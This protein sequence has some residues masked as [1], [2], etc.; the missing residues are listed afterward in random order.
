M[1]GTDSQKKNYWCIFG[2]QR[3]GVTSFRCCWSVANQVLVVLV[4]SRAG[5]GCFPGVGFRHL[6]TLR[7]SGFLLYLG[8]G[9]WATLRTLLDGF[10]VEGARPEHVR[11]HIFVN[12]C[13]FHR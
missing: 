1:F 9:F 11:G 8:K 5:W 6:G 3:P 10:R 7:P 12:P 2:F 13:V 4:V